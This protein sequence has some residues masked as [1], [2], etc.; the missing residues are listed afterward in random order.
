MIDIPD[1]SSPLF[2]F[3]YLFTFYSLS[4]CINSNNTHTNNVKIRK[5]IEFSLQNGK[6]MFLV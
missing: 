4:F 5:C 6:Y 3:D 2:L 1:A